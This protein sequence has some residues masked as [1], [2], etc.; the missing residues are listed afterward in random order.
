[1][2]NKLGRPTQPSNNPA[3][4][5]PG[6][7]ASGFEVITD[8]DLTSFEST[9]LETA[10][11]CNQTISVEPDSQQPKQMKNSKH[12]KSEKHFCD[13]TDCNRS[14]SR[15]GFFRKDHL[16]QHLR[17][18]HKQSLVPRIR[19]KSNT[20][21]NSSNLPSSTED[22]QMFL[23]SKKRKHDSEVRSSQLSTEELMKMVDEEQS[24]RR[25]V[26]QENTHLQQKIE[27]YE[28]RMEKYENRLDKLTT[29][30]ENEKRKN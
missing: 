23:Q 3:G 11:S 29:L 20:V 18:R 1:A 22:P 15:I 17:G 10:D 5:L 8:Q 13:Y 14:R 4:S 2:H 9:Q 28:E 21:L 7:E 12:G 16:D 6:E 27:K 19:A 26:E 24:K 25:Q 30:L